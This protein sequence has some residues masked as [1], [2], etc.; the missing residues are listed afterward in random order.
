MVEFWTLCST[1]NISIEKESIEIF[2]RYG[3]ALLG[4]KQFSHVIVIW[5][6]HENDTP[7]KRGTLRV[8]PMGNQAILL[9]G[10]FA[11]RSPQRPN[12]IAISV[13]KLMSEE[14]NHLHIDGIDARNGTPVIDVKP[15]IPE[16]DSIPE[17]EVPRWVGERNK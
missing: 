5:W 17:A 12:P 1:N 7:E 13:C 3:D 10:V 16:S 15:Y 2:E 8:H 11:T 4:L 14:R 6:F 9:T